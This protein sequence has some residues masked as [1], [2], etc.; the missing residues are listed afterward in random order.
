MPDKASRTVT[1]A[2]ERDSKKKEDDVESVEMVEEMDDEE[3]DDES[4]DETREMRVR[5]KVRGSPILSVNYRLLF[6]SKF[7]AKGFFFSLK[8]ILNIF[9]NLTKNI[10][11]FELLQKILFLMQIFFKFQNFLMCQIL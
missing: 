11:F 3:F 10:F 6:V 4:C 5:F 1:P 9:L 7:V 2:S 8:R